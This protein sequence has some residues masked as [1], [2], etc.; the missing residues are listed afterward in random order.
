MGL[1]HLTSEAKT[2]PKRTGRILHA[3]PSMNRT[4]SRYAQHLENER[5]AG[6]IQCWQFEAIRLR[7]AAYTF[8][9]PDFLVEDT[10]GHL[11]ILEVKGYLR[12]DASLK[13]KAIQS[14]FP[15]FRFVM[16]HPHKK[17]WDIIMRS[18]N[19]DPLPEWL[20]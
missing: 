12:D 17:G 5:K 20:Y 18:A 3:E 1:G 6:H 4:E 9:N 10:E 13:Y 11:W 2:P 16:I 19:T 14:K 8:Y 7:L 15:F